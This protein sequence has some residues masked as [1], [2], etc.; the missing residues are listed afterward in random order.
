MTA[1]W[2]YKQ[3]EQGWAREDDGWVRG[4]WTVGH[5]AGEQFIPE[6]DHGSPEAAAD[7]VRW[8]NGGPA[9]DPTAEEERGYLHGLTAAFQSALHALDDTSGLAVDTEDLEW[10]QGRIRVVA[11]TYGITLDEPDRTDDSDRTSIPLDTV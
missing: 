3:T 1:T 7:R 8:L 11:S 2:I 9:A 4:L 6:S 10:F 5:Y